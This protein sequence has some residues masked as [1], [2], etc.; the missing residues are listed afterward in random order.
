LRKIKKSPETEVWYLDETRFG[1]Q[2]RLSKEWNVKGSR[3]QKP[4]QIQ[5]ENAW[6]YGA[7]NPDSGDHFGLILPSVNGECAKIFMKHLHEYIDPERK[8]V[9][10]MD[11][12][13]WHYSHS[14]SHNI[15]T[16]F[17]PPYSPELNPIERLWLWIKDNYLSNKIFANYQELIEAGTFAW[18]QVTAKI[19]KNIGMGYTY[20]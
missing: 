4:Q 20:T 5:Y 10:V 15:I 7:I 8:V 6:I 1:Q 17:L 9:L 2:G 19:V 11:Q 16:L 3:P 14:D 12:A 13:K 18:N